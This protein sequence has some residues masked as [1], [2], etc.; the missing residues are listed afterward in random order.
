MVGV[1]LAPFLRSRISRINVV[2]KSLF[3]APPQVRP[4]S[5]KQRVVP[6]LGKRHGIRDAHCVHYVLFASM[7]LR[8]SP[9]HPVANLRDASDSRLAGR[10]SADAKEGI[11]REAE[12][13][14]HDIRVQFHDPQPNRLI[15]RGS[16]SSPEGRCHSLVFPKIASTMPS[17]CHPRTS[18]AYF[19][20]AS[21]TSHSLAPRA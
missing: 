12:V 9:H 10:Q 13:A 1:R 16:R 17:L 4:F 19:S 3:L 8:S 6:I 21:G 20:N 2:A 15:S 7:P 11:R 5:L 14:G 18:S